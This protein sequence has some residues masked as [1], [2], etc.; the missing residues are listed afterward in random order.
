MQ[1][2]EDASGGFQGGRPP[3]KV[4]ADRYDAIRWALENGREKDILMLLG[5]G[6]EDYQVLEYGTI[7]FDERFIVRELAEKLREQDSI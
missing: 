6:H 3:V 2:I 4:I 5:K 1:I 7:F